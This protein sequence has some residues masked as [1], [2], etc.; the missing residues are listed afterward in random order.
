LATFQEYLG[1][2]RGCQNGTATGG[3]N[4]KTLCVKDNNSTE[5]NSC[6]ICPANQGPDTADDGCYWVTNM[7]GPCENFWVSD[8]SGVL[9]LPHWG[10]Y[11]ANGSGYYNMD[12][13]AMRARCVVPK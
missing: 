8:A 5:Y 1:I 6:G 7:S 3:A 12:G 4:D 11:P 9:G 13:F 2:V 10:A